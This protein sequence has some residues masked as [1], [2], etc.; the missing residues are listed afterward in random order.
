MINTE[1]YLLF[2]KGEFWLLAAPKPIIR[3]GWKKGKFVL[4]QMLATGG[5]TT[6]VCP[7]ADALRWQPRGKSLYK[8]KEEVPGRNST[9]SSDSHLQVWLVVVWPVPSWPFQVQLIFSSRASSFPSLGGQMSD[10]WQL[11]SWL[12]SGHRVTSL[13]PP[14]GVSSIYKTAQRIWLRILSVILE[15]ELKI[16]DFA[17][18]LHYYLIFFDSFLFLHVPLSLITL[19]LWLKFSTDKWQAEDQQGS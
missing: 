10:L 19:S 14:G 1:Q 7:K 5:R 17:E 15:E 8:Q 12:Q 2:P 16:L 13:V 4:F 3:P 11:L 6:D 9:I 18:W